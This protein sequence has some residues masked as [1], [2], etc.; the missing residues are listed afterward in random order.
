[1]IGTH[2]PAAGRLA[3]INR[4]VGFVEGRPVLAS[5]VLVLLLLS[6]T[7]ALLHPGYQSSDDAAMALYAA[8]VAI[9]DTPDAHLLFMHAWIGWV[10][11]LLYTVWPTVPWYALFLYAS[12][13][14]AHLVVLWSLR[15]RHG[16]AETLLLF[17]VL[18][19]ISLGVFGQELQFTIVAM[20]CTA[21]GWLAVTTHALHEGRADR[22]GWLVG[23]LALLIGAS[24][25]SISFVIATLLCAPLVLHGWAAS[26]R[27]GRRQLAILTVAAGAGWAL[28]HGL[29]AEYYRADPG[30][31][32]FYEY[33]ALRA[34]FNDFQ[35]IRYNARTRAA[36]ETVGW[37]K[38]D[39][40]MIKNWFYADPGTFSAEKMR[41]VV[42]LIGA[43]GTDVLGKQT[44]RRVWRA[45]STPY[46]LGAVIII[47][48]IGAVWGFRRV[49]PVVW[50]LVVAVLLIV[51]VSVL[52][53][54]M[55]PRISITIAGL[56]ALS[57]SFLAAPRS[58]SVT[59]RP[60][61]SL[62]A[63][64]MMLAVAGYTG[65]SVLRDVRQADAREQQQ[66]A[67]EAD[68][69]E[70]APP[71]SE[72]FVAWGE[73][74]PMKYI[75][76]LAPQL[77]EMRILPLGAELGT[78][79]VA[80]TLLRFGIGDLYLALASRP[81]VFLI[82]DEEKYGLDVTVRPSFHGRTFDVYTVESK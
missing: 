11:S 49:Q 51:A 40:L 17:L 33:N 43:Y 70:L 71:P 61:R 36:F 20:Y 42:S 1:V 60:W 7:I 38:T 77:G 24:V 79:H 21:A 50:T 69:R 81:D 27:T 8:G 29:N 54:P 41:H 44:W 57:A 62:V 53:K 52:L 48:W 2:P 82:S 26:T 68:I 56:C 31:A 9:R 5:V 64:A 58:V 30:W 13:A 4:A 67:F 10:L 12:L 75:D 66:R 74:F 19:G 59:R 73:A 35:V 72:L 6:A 18:F 55:P 45:F 23:L 32:S 28:L 37:S 34:N 63:M 14:V 25:R 76:P 78:P 3:R 22:G 65:W 16:M 47:G 39:Y 15:R 46:W 80:G